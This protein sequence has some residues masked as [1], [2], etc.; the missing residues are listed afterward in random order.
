MAFEEGAGQAAPLQEGA[1]QA[2]PS[3]IPPRQFDL[4]SADSIATWT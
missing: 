1:G 4:L 2:A 3:G